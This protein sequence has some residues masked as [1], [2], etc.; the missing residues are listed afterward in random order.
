VFFLS[1]NLHVFSKE[2][3]T[4][5][6]FKNTKN[7]E[8]KARKALYLWEHYLRNDVDSLLIVAR[9]LAQQRNQTAFSRAVSKRI[10]ACYQVRRGQI[11]DGINYL[12]ES[13]NHFL[14]IGDMELLCEELNELGIAYYLLGDLESAAYYFK[15][16]LSTGAQSVNES[17]AIL[18]EVNLAKVY[19]GLKDFKQANAI[20]NHYIFR[21]KELKKWEAVANAYS[22]LADVNLSLKKYDLAKLYCKRQL[23]FAKKGNSLQLKINALNNQALIYFFEGDLSKSLRL[24]EE[25]L[26]IRKK[27][28]IPSK[29]YDAYFNLAGFYVE[30]KPK[31][32]ENY[33][34]SCIEIAQK[35]NYLQMHLEAIQFKQEELQL[36]NLSAEVDKIKAKIE[37]LNQQNNKDREEVNALLQQTIEPIKEERNWSMVIGLIGVIM[38]CFIALR[39]YMNY[40]ANTKVK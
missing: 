2:T 36:E 3:V 12:K 11:L 40:S 5:K 20:I 28:G 22:V 26:T 4:Y 38:F 15:A 33:I 18:A 19:I 35:N 13:K 1:I 39:F 32:A 10:F 6:E 27:Q 17:D 8:D 34:D 25:I 24:F 14:T 37:T 29:I 21:A 9:D 31:I 30:N 7:S 23:F 16:S